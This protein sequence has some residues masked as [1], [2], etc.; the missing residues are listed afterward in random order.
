M[1]REARVLQRVELLAVLAVLAVLAALAALAALAVLTVL[2]VLA[3][4]RQSRFHPSDPIVST[5]LR[6]PLFLQPTQPDSL[7]LWAPQQER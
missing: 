2:T 5:T 1:S 6:A 3:A 4:Q 7:Q